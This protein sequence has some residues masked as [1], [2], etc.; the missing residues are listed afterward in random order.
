MSAVL[1]DKAADGRAD[2]EKITIGTM[3][4]R[5]RFISFTAIANSTVAMKRVKIGITLCTSSYLWR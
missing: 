5:N 3:G 2:L 1:A 4:E